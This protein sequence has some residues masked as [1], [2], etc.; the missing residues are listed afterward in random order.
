M[1]KNSYLQQIKFRTPRVEILYTWRTVNEYELMP[2]LRPKGYYSHLSAMHFHGLLDEEPAIIYFND[3]QPSR[4]VS[5]TLEQSRIDNAFQ[6]NQR[7]T[8]ART[9]YAEK[10]FWLL[11]G[12]QTGNYGVF[13]IRTL[14]GINAS[15][16]DLE[17]TL[18]DATVRPA[19]S[20]GVKNVLR[21]YRLA[22][23]QISIE[24]MVSTLHVLNYIYPYHQSIGFYIDASGVYNQSDFQKFLNFAPL[25][26]N[27]Y[28]DYKI[29]KP[30]YSEKWKIYY[31]EDLM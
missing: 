24:K 22:Q 28:L 9:I 30:V 25:Q 5:G 16:T 29:T 19:Y 14:T 27:F 11:N 3:E 21:A 6:K 20:G 23:P 31:P 7:L 18:I 10:E 26:H 8:T 4:S 13:P 12:K 15:M 2:V 1:I 17:R